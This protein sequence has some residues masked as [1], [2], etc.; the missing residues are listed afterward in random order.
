MVSN[1]P[2]DLHK[3]LEELKRQ[4]GIEEPEPV[5]DLHKELEE[6][7][8]RAG[9]PSK[10][11]KHRRVRDLHRELEET[12]RS[13][14]ELEMQVAPEQASERQIARAEETLKQAESY[15]SG[16][17][18]VTW[19]AETY[20][21]GT[22][23]GWKDYRQALRERRSEVQA[24]KRGLKEYRFAAISRRAP[25]PV[26]GTRVPYTTKELR[27][28]GPPKIATAADRR[29]LEAE[30][31]ELPE[32]KT[33]YISPAGEVY[34]YEEEIPDA[35]LSLS[36]KLWAEAMA[37]PESATGRFLGVPYSERGVRQIGAVLAGAAERATTPV[38]RLIPGQQ[39]LEVTPEMD[40]FTLY[41]LA[42]AKELSE[43]QKRVALATGVTAEAALTAGVSYTAGYVGGAVIGASGA[44]VS[45]IPVVGPAIERGGAYVAGKLSTPLGGALML[46]GIAAVEAPRVIDLVKEDKAIGYELLLEASR[47]G[48]GSFGVTHGISFGK[49]LPA[50]AERALF[51]GTTIAEPSIVPENVLEGEGRFPRFKSEPYEP[52][53]AGYKE[54]AE[55][56]APLEMRVTEDGIPS[57]HATPGRMKG[58]T[59]EGFTTQAGVRPGEGGM[60]YSPAASKHF[61]RL[62]DSGYSLR[63]GVP[64][65]F[66]EPQ[67]V[68]GEFPG[69][70]ATGLGK[71]SP[72]LAKLLKE[73]AGTGR[74][75]MPAEQMSE[76]QAVL[77]PGTEMAKVVEGRFWADIGGKPVK[78]ERFLP[79]GAFPE[80][81]TGGVETVERLMAK[82]SSL[83]RSTPT[84]YVPFL[85]PAAAKETKSL[86][87]EMKRISSTMSKAGSF[88]V[89]SSTLSLPSIPGIPGITSSTRAER[90]PSK[91]SRGGPSYTTPGLPSIEYPSPG[92]DYPT[93]SPPPSE[94]W[95]DHPTT[96]SPS[97]VEPSGITDITP[98]P[99]PSYPAADYPS[100]IVEPTRKRGK[101]GKKKRKTAAE[102]RLDPLAMTFPT[103]KVPD[104]TIPQVTVPSMD[105]EIPGLTG[106]K[107][108]KS[109][110][111]R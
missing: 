30:G 103:V 99:V 17:G 34:Y 14:D 1:P 49:T 66:G 37:T 5:R 22:T 108:R 84:T 24:A 19:G 85:S 91:P 29:R 45:R 78:I 12:K 90:K 33:I 56:Y 38:T 55:K 50:R 89:P 23:R 48:G 69:V 42:A 93:P 58:A 95:K 35:P 28:T 31:Y 63:P 51:R 97:R 77:G 36:A 9:V 65:I 88:T 73:S 61:L 26:T 106:K 80:I 54:F 11:Q 72:E 2:R 86:E 18:T 13:A 41:N 40:T 68:Y 100:S 105:V 101:K 109:K 16:G 57:W 60:F 3:S 27:E 43:T 76:A 15:K 4:A 64:N 52:T 53:A 82:A 104:V 102:R 20:D 71:R 62:S 44:L 75:F 70:T 87:R 8:R 98:P 111:K 83:G 46:G 10:T 25:E 96:P 21:L 81:T 59:P 107:K 6:T 32:D 110:K 92:G 94:P 79:K 67:L 74:L 7:K 47:F 39:P